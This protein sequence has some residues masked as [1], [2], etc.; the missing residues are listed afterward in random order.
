MNTKKSNENS[1][2]L[3]HLIGG[4]KGGVGKTF[5]SRAL[6]QYF[7]GKDSTFVL[8]EA[9]SQ[10][11]DVGRIYEHQAAQLHTISLSD[12]PS[13]ATEPDTIFNAA[14][15]APVIVNL[16]SNTQSVLQRWMERVELLDFMQEHYGGQYIVQ[17]FVTD[18]CHESIRQLDASI[19]AFDNRI[20]H[21]VVLNEGRLNG[22][23]FNYLSEDILYQQIK[24]KPNLVTE[25]LFPPLENAIQY[26][27]DKNEWTL[28]D[29]V[30]QIAEDQGILS[31]QRVVTFIKGYTQAFD[32]A[33]EELQTRLKE[34]GNKSSTVITIPDAQEP[35]EE[36]KDSGNNTK[37][38]E[39]PEVDCD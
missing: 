1:L 19:S 28:E 16:P 12:D 25:I 3:I 34:W 10:I 30:E 7:T 29:A 5:T 15:Q 21:I 32:R 22:S 11:N 24:Q 37:D 39:P 18:G 17:W 31:K 6:A 23:D 9:D 33:L 35:K 4:E 26:Q 20:P 27:I 36:S 14:T 13:R 38:R 2:H 8:V